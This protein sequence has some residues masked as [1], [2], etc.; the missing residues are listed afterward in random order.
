MTRTSETRRDSRTKVDDR[1]RQ[2]DVGRGELPTEDD[3]QPRA[4]VSDT[5]VY[6]GDLEAL[7]G[8][9]PSGGPEVD[10]LAETELRVDETD[11]PSVAAEE[12][13]PW[14]APIDP[15]AVGSDEHG[16]PQVAAGFSVDAAAEPYDQDHHDDLLDGEDEIVARVRE[17]LEADARTSSL[18]DLLTIQQVGRRVV[19][20]GVV[21]DLVDEDEVVDV[22]EHVVD[23]DEVVSRLTIRALD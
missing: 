8:E 11:D 5:G 18:A 12:G 2:L 19:L 7:G 20:R 1:E 17:A 23:V 4:S 14:I 15:P 3:L 22:V 13:I 9:A 10:P 6:Q 21:D 16:D